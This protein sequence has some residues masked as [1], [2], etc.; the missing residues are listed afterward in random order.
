MEFVKNGATYVLTPQEKEIYDKTKKLPNGVTI[1]PNQPNDANSENTKRNSNGVQYFK[2]GDKLPKGNNGTLAD[3]ETKASV[4]KFPAFK[5]TQEGAYGTY[6]EFVSDALN[7]MQQNRVRGFAHQGK[8]VELQNG[9]T[10]AAF[11][12]ENGTQLRKCVD[13]NGT[14]VWLSV[15]G[16]TVAPDKDAPI[17]VAC[18]SGRVDYPQ[19]MV[20]GQPLLNHLTKKMVEISSSVYSDLR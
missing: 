2:A 4:S 1:A 15:Q 10:V 14:K 13:L 19:L 12:T 20:K 7:Q 3:I 9:A 11:T 8:I 6:A 17:Y 5:A 16:D 18:I